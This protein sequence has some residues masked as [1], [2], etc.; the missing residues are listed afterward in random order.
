MSATLTPWGRIQ[1]LSAFW[2]PDI[3]VPVG[4][5]WLAY[6]RN[7][8][9]DNDDA[10]TLDEPYDLATDTPLGGYDRIF[11]GTLDSSNWGFTGFSEVYNL[12]TYTSDAAT[13]AWGLMQGYALLD[14]GTL[15]EGNVF[16]VG[17]VIDPF[18]ISKA[19]D[20]PPP[21][22]VGGLALGLYD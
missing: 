7:L 11:L 20:T 2:T 9:V 12:H 16:G 10:T 8:P 19:G 3:Y 4:G 15:G 22:D 1:L 6:T 13:D 5:L 14:S 17:E 18:Q 21:I